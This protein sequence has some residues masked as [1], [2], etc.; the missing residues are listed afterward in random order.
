MPAA[1]EMDAHIKRFGS[2]MPVHN[3]LLIEQGVH[4]AE[5]HNLEELARSKAYE[6][7]YICLTN[8]IRGSTAGFTLR[9]VAL[10]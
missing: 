3:Y 2:F 9:P 6:F 8:K 5:L 4:I 1:E 7:C 10:R